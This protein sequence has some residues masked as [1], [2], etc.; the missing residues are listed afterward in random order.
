[1]YTFQV[2]MDVNRIP[3]GGATAI[4]LQLGITGEVN[5]R[6]ANDGKWILEICSEKAVKEEALTVFG[7]IQKMSGTAEA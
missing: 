3:P 2:E 1:L 5:L 7:T 4:L 6:P